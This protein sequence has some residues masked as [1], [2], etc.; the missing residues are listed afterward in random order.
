PALQRGLRKLI[1]RAW[2]IPVLRV[3]RDK[4]SL[5]ATPALWPAIEAALSSSTYFVLLASPEAAR[6]SWVERE[7]EWWLKHRPAHHLLRALPDR[8]LAWRAVQPDFGSSGAAALPACLFGQFHQEPGWGDMC[9]A[10][11]VER[12][13]VGRQQLR[14][15]VLD[16]AARLLGRAKDEL[17]DAQ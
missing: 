14:S 16:I 12:L 2:L 10:K 4:T 9:W 11:K 8:S 13:T 3:F 15:C 7:I 17:D 6:S 1:R 5:S